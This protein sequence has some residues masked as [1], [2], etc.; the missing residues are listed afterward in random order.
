MRRQPRSPLL[1]VLLGLM[2]FA[3]AFGAAG[4]HAADRI[5][6]RAA[7]YRPARS[8]LR[9]EGVAAEGSGEVLIRDA[10]SKALLGCA[11]VR[12][13]GVWMLKLRKP[14]H[15]P[16]RLSAECDGAVAVSEVATQR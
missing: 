15:V 10:D 2:L 3:G 13:D 7:R 14:R 8:E 9:I 11:A 12:S 6:I 4:G 5:E 1:P 16:A